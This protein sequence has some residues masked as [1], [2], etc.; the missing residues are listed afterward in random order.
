MDDR[1]NAAA[2]VIKSQQGDAFLQFMANAYH[3]SAHANGDTLSVEGLQY[4]ERIGMVRRVGDSVELTT[5]GF[6][7]GNIS[8]EYR[9]YLQSGRA[10][11]AP[12][13]PVEMYA[14]KDVLDV[15]CSFGRSLWEFQ[16]AA[17]STCGIEPQE[18]YA[19]L[20]A[21]LSAR[22]GVPP[23]KILVGP[24]EQI[25]T[26]TNSQQFDFIFSRLVLTYVKIRP[27]LEKMIAALRPGG[28]LWIQVDP[29]SILLR[30]LCN[31]QD[32]LP[33]RLWVA[34]ALANIPICITTGRQLSLKSRGRMQTRHNP[35]Y[36]PLWWW[37]LELL[38]SGM[39]NFKVYPSNSYVFSAEKACL[40]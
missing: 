23:P 5:P 31:R 27:V 3:G 20:G 38:R 4:A 12:R 34:L 28:V 26:L 13:P 15:G 37:R 24:A 21:A 22:E 2:E 11:P 39:N 6:L 1:I 33:R 8:K 9:Y 35:G 32:S 18:E 29:P 25:D 7:V 36:L 14:G 17:R 16:R 40:P 30:R 10:T 19:L